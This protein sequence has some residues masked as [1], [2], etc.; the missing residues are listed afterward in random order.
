MSSHQLN[1][2]NNGL[3]CIKDY[4]KIPIISP[5]LI[6]V[7]KAFLLGLFSGELTFRAACYWKEFCV[8]KWVGLDN[9]KQCKTLRKQ[10]K[11]A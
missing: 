10:P 7:P 11:N 3:V 8:S 6:F 9:K 1:S 2:K 4:R 5:G